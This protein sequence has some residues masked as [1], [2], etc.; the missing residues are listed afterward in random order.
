MMTGASLNLVQLNAQSALAVCSSVE[1]VAVEGVAAA[2]LEGRWE[3]AVEN[4]DSNLE[5]KEEK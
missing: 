1:G 4:V 2:A 5:E 3:F